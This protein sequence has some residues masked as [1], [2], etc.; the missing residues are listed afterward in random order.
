MREKIAVEKFIIN[1]SDKQLKTTNNSTRI[2][3]ILK[4][5]FV[6]IHRYDMCLEQIRNESSMNLMNAK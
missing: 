4:I 1:L 5:Y 2:V 3:P 6:K